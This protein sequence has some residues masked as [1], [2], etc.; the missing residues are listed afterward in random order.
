LDDFPSAAATD[1]AEIKASL[2]ASGKPI[3]PY[4][5]LIAAQARHALATLVTNNEGE[6]RRV[7]R[8]TVENW[9]KA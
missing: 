9:L 8:L 4:D 3:G 7:P 2:H 5:M 6:F 1:F